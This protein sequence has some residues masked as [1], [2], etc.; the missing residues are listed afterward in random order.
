MGDVM[1]TTQISVLLIE[2]APPFAEVLLEELRHGGFEPDAR[3]VETASEI[4]AA[5]DERRWDIVLADDSLPAFKGS[6]ILA[7]LAERGLDVPVILVSGTIDEEDA[8]GTLRA[9]AKDFIPK[10]RLARLLPSV[11]RELAAAE[12]RAASRRADQRFRSLVEHLPL[13]TYVDAI[14]TLSTNIYSSPQIEAMLGYTA[15]EWRRDPR[16]FVDVLHP[17][18]R[19]RVLDAQRAAH[20]QR[21][22]L[23]IEYRVF[24]KD[25]RIVWLRDEAVVV[26]GEAGAPDYLQGFLVDITAERDHEQELIRGQRLEALSHLAAGVAHDFNNMLTAI[27]AAAS[28]ASMTLTARPVDVGRVQAKLGLIDEVVDHASSLTRGLLDFGRIVQLEEATFDVNVLVERL[29]PLL[30]SGGLGVQ[31]DFFPAGRAALVATDARRLE[32]AIFN[33]ALNARDAMPN[34]GRL[35]IAVTHVRYEHDAQLPAHELEPGTTYCRIT[36]ADTGVGM[37]EQTRTRIFEP[38]FTTKGERGTGLGLA[39]VYGLA[40][41]AG[42]AIT[43]KSSPGDGTTF[44]LYL[45]ASEQA[46]SASARAVGDAEP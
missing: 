30:E 9:G 1:T 33:L 22:P 42:G 14:D 3:R 16:L 36:V 19:E 38:Y 28:L 43:V 31:L 27:R 21:T 13:V 40:R 32:Q 45:P 23:R 35:T 4:A 10:D 25:G 6:D 37:D 17:E 12:T 24:A 20:E 39:S 34:G 29:L 41:Q 18:D 8:L 5:L 44:D 2:D 7:M 11:A 26:R 46:G 15:E